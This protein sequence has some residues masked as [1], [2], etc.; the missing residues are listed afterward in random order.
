MILSQIYSPFMTAKI[1]EIPVAVVS[2]VLHLGWEFLHAPFFIFD[3][4]SSPTSLAGCLLFCS[5]VDIV[6]SL[7]AYCSVS[8]TWRDRGWLME[9]N[10]GH[11]SAFVGIALL[12]AVVSEYTAMHY[13]NLWEYSAHMPVIPFVEI[14]L[15]PVLQ[16]LI[17]PPIT[18]VL[19]KSW[20]DSDY[21][22]RRIAG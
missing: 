5:G 19:S 15:T 1:P 22:I 17:L 13:R 16:W 8:L 9:K 4:Q 3:Q 20:S 2:F 11:V 6:M 18:P 21:K 14:G 7:A 10:F 12:L